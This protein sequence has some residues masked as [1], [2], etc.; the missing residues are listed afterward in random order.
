MS[1]PIADTE[2]LGN[3]VVLTAEQSERLAQLE[4]VVS[5]GINKVIEVAQALASIRAENLFRGTHRTWTEYLRDKWAMSLSTASQYSRF[6]GV[7]SDLADCPVQPRT[8]QSVLPLNAADPK[9]RATIWDCSV[10]QAGGSTPSRALVQAVRDSLGARKDNSGRKSDSYKPKSVESPGPVDISSPEQWL[11]QLQQLAEEQRLIEYRIG[12]LYNQGE[13][14]YGEAHKLIEEIEFR[15]PSTQELR[16]LARVAKIVPADKRKSISFDVAA[17]VVYAGKPEIIEECSNEEQIREAVAEVRKVERADKARAETGVA[18]EADEI[19]D[20]FFRM[21][22]RIWLAV[23]RH[24]GESEEGQLL[25]L[26]NEFLASRRDWL[27][28]K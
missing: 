6:A 20:E 27:K 11:S 7:L 25:V 5:R 24:F 22:D 18:L 3:L 16:K 2:Q 23:T 21:F 17:K 13:D 28:I 4:N 1:Q 12:D 8:Y 26:A 19:K 9:D 15:G 10:E 14:T